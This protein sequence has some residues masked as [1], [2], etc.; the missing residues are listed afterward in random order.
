MDFAA[1]AA[2]RAQFAPI[3]EWVDKRGASGETKAPVA[4]PF[5]S[6]LSIPGR[7]TL[8]VIGKGL[9]AS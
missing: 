6:T 5:H 7:A 1:A 9:S 3:V 4:V 8:R 2:E